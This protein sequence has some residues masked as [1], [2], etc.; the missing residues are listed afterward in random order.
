MIKEFIAD[1]KRI[2]VKNLESTQQTAW[3]SFVLGMATVTV[4]LEFILTEQYL[5]LILTLA[6][7]IAFPFFCMFNKQRH[8]NNY[9][10]A[11]FIINIVFIFMGLHSLSL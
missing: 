2:Y 9:L 3:L 10:T 5:Y 7:L 4:A 6:D 8:K 11:I 1:R